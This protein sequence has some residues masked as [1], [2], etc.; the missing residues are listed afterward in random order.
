MSLPAVFNAL[1]LPVIGA[2]LF[3]ISNPKL[4]P[5]FKIFIWE[6]FKQNGLRRKK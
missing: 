2:P 5:R 6:Y 1:R 3:I 4:V